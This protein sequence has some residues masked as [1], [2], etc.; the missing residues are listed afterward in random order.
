MTGAPPPPPP[1]VVPV[2]DVLTARESLALAQRRLD[3]TTSRLVS[4]TEDERQQRVD[5]EWSAVE[6][7]RHLV[8]TIDLLFTELHAHDR[9]INRDLDHLEAART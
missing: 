7:L 3:A 1:P 8:L 4:F 2:P 6:S 5:D 9:F